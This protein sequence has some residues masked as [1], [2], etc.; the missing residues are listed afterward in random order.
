[1]TSAMIELMSL[2]RLGGAKS[3]CHWRAINTG[4]RRYPMVNGGHTAAQL[5]AHHPAGHGDLQ[6][7]GQGFESPKLHQ[8][9]HRI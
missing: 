6:A 3:L 1:M 7:G 9:K 2:I 5:T 4:H 8:A